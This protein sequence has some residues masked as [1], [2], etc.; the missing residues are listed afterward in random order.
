[1]RFG[2]APLR[3]VRAGGVKFIEA[4]RPEL[5]DLQ[6]D[7]GELQNTYQADNKTV[8]EFRGML[9]DARPVSATASPS[10]LPDP[11]DKIEEQNLLHTAMMATD[12]NRV[13]EARAALEKV[14]Q[15]D[16]KSST[17]LRQI[18]ELELNAADY[19]K[20]ADYLTRARQF[21]PDDATVAF[22]QGKA[23]HKT[24]DLAGAREALE[25]SLKLLPAQLPARIL[26]GEVY[27]GLKDVKAA[28][29]QFEAAMLLQPNSL[30][31]QLG[32]AKAQ[33]EQGSFT[34]ALQQLQPLVQSQPN[35]A[36]VF[37]LLAQCYT[38]L[39]KASEAARAAN[40]AK[41]LQK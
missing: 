21:W 6:T 34:E 20:A 9:S 8:A 26:L 5:Y 10:T 39:G 41:A 19:P 40:R 31:A 15:S 13:S 14:L 22:N 25:A 16:P 29:D 28:E 23:L 17:A 18:G 24:G 7:P 4:P 3:S 2:W 33:I 32:S 36:A 30:D 27:L 12:D 35:N 38:G 37:D 11:K 1:L